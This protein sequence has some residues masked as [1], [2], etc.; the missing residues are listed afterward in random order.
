MVIDRI[1]FVD[2]RELLSIAN[3]KGGWKFID[4]GE[5]DSLLNL[6]DKQIVT[7]Q[8][9]SATN[10]LKGLA[11]LGEKCGIIGKVGNDHHSHSFMQKMQNQGIAALYQETPL[12]SKQVVCL[13]TPDGQ[14][15]FRT[16]NGAAAE[17]N[18]LQLNL[19]HFKGTQLVHVTGYLLFEESLVLKI[20]KLAKQAGA[21]VSLDLANFKK[22]QAH[23]NYILNLLPEYV[24]ILFGNAEEIEEL[25]KLPPEE[26]AD[27]L[28]ELCEVVVVTTGVNGGWIRSGEKKI[29]YDALLKTALDSTGAGDCFASGFLYGYINHCPLEKCGQMGALIAS[30]VVQVPGAEIDDAMWVNIR[31]DL[32]L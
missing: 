20:M 30:Y 10:V 31:S 17:L 9:G 28:G 27:K 3:E 8:G 12:P 14:R 7:L 16:F 13:V 18:Q 23:R 4:E 32:N 22:V 2:D 24:D 19:S 29:H 6:P 26:A 11:K 15:T 21:K 5:L 1:I 25:V